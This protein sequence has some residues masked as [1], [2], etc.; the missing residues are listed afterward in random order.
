MGAGPKVLCSEILISRPGNN[1]IK[2]TGSDLRNVDETD[3]GSELLALDLDGRD[4]ISSLHTKSAPC[5]NQDGKPCIAAADV[6]VNMVHIKAPPTRMRTPPT[7]Y[8]GM[9]GPRRGVSVPCAT[10]VT[11]NNAIIG[12]ICIEDD[13]ASS[14]RETWKI[15]GVQ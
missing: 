14:P 9:W 11:M 2:D 15:R 4:G 7:R 12:I 13:I 1:E 10:T 5:A 8:Q 6:S 3:S